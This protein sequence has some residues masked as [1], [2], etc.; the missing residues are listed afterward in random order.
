MTLPQRLSF[1]III[2]MMVLSV[3]GRLRADLVAMLAL[4]VSLPAGTVAPE[5]AFP[6]FSG[7]IAV[8]V[9]SALVVSAAVSRSGMI[10]VAL[11]WLLRKLG[12]SRAQL[13]VLVGSVTILSA[14]IKNIGALAMMMPDR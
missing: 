3:W 13:L 9:G 4:A 6:G 2:G 1:A 5:D 10:G 12:N 7:D 8:I 14:M 11:R